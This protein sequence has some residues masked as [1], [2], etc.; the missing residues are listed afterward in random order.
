LGEKDSGGGR[1]KLARIY[2]AYGKKRSAGDKKKTTE[3]LKG[4]PRLEK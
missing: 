3:K 2:I 4:Y 1:R